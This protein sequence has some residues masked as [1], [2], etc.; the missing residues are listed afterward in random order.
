[1]FCDLKKRKQ[2]LERVLLVHI[3]N[4][5]QALNGRFSLHSV[6]DGSINPVSVP[7]R[8]VHVENGT[9]DTNNLFQVREERDI[10]V[11]VPEDEPFRPSV[12]LTCD[13]TGLLWDVT[14]KTIVG[15]YHMNTVSHIVICNYD[16]GG[17][18]FSTINTTDIFRSLVKELPFYHLFVTNR[19]YRKTTKEGTIIQCTFLQRDAFSTLVD[20]GIEVYFQNDPEEEI[21]S[22]MVALKMENGALKLYAQT[23]LQ[24]FTRVRFT[25]RIVDVADIES[26]IAMLDGE[27]FQ[28]GLFE[29]SFNR[30]QLPLTYSLFDFMVFSYG[31]HK[32]PN[33]S[34]DENVKSIIGNI[35]KVRDFY[36]RNII[37]FLICFGQLS[38][39][40]GIEL[41]LSAKKLPNKIID[42]NNLKM[43]KQLHLF[44]TENNGE[45]ISLREMIEESDLLGMT[46]SGY[47]GD[48][49]FELDLDD[50][51]N[52]L[53]AA[54]RLAKRKVFSFSE[55]AELTQSVDNIMTNFKKYYNTKKGTPKRLTDDF[56]SCSEKINKMKRMKET[57]ESDVTIVTFVGPCNSGKSFVISGIALCSESN[58]EHWDLLLSEGSEATT[59][60]V[61]KFPALVKYN[62]DPSDE[63]VHVTLYFSESILEEFEEVTLSDSDQAPWKGLYK[64]EIE[65][66]SNITLKE[67]CALVK[68]VLKTCNEG[69]FAK[70]VAF[71]EI[72][73]PFEYL[74]QHKLYLIDVSTSVAFNSFQ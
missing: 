37:P 28:N 44:S 58:G 26:E 52:Q 8:L 17:D 23:P 68:T 67:R 11:S 21:R 30:L 15:C 35:I 39:L 46:C 61:T 50:R 69:T 18:V 38:M 71:V 62:D 32:K 59:N 60:S 41:F 36:G 54:L 53:L 14:S 56:K 4:T 16:D 13:K 49:S 6:E 10:I 1:V 3:D 45:L 33:Q 29:V 22:E 25:R 9:V 12:L 47:I 42:F 40:D 73:G 72:S 43:L 24:H 63:Q 66:P 7:I 2:D 31:Y 57:K 64:M 19:L 74:R 65:Q 20:V 48:V 55:M 70:H 34:K 51:Y 27:Q 5:K